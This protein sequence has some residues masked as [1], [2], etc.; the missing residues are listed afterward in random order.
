MEEIEFT[1]LY[2]TLLY[3]YGY[4]YHDVSF[5][6]LKGYM[7]ELKKIMESFDMLKKYQDI[8]KL[9]EISEDNNYD[10]F[11]NLILIATE[12][13]KYSYINLKSEIII[14]NLTEEK[15]KKIIE[16]SKPV[17][18]LEVDKIVNYMINYINQKIKIKV[19]TK[20]N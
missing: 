8:N 7:H 4:C 11:I 14:I 17:N 3:K 19:I 2:I 10:R 16:N 18:V 12:N 15:I 9:F 1:K 6:Y 20:K 13:P 5:E